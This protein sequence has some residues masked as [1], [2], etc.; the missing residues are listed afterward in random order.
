MA[1]IRFSGISATELEDLKAV[2][3]LIERGKQQDAVEGKQ[4]AVLLG[5][6][7]HSQFWWPS[8]AEQDAWVKKW[9]AADEQ[10]RDTDSSLKTPWDYAL[11]VS[12]LNHAD[13]QLTGLNVDEHGK[14]EMVYQPLV[15][16]HCDI[17]AFEHI[18]KMFGAILLS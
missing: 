15:T 5:E 17:V 18:V 11:W 13:I 1:V 14:G 3:A 16:S 9:I 12:A 8:E 10:T 2:F 4:L 7:Y 6:R